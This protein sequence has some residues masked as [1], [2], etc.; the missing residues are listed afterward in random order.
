MQDFSRQGAID[1]K[2][3]KILTFI[4]YIGCGISVIFLAATVLT[5]LAFE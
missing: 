2:Q 1:K 3:A 4:T 5:Y